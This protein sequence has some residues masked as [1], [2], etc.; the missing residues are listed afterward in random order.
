MANEHKL[1]QNIFSA[2]FFPSTFNENCCAEEL[3]K[4]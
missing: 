3:Q 4:K 2:N 1:N